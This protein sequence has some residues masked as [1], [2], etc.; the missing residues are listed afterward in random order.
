MIISSTSHFCQQPQNDSHKVQQQLGENVIS[1]LCHLNT[2]EFGNTTTLGFVTLSIM[3]LGVRTLSIMT[4]SITTISIPSL[5][6]LVLQ[7][8]ALPHSKTVKIGTLHFLLGVTI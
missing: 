3:T 8:P 1:L 7:Q 5:I 2:L 6:I 4:L